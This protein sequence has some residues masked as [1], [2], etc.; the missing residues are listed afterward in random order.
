M[1]AKR[2]TVCIS[3]A[4]GERLKRQARMNDCSRSAVV[5]CALENYLDSIS[6]CRS[7]YDLAVDA[8]LISHLHGTPT[9]LSV[10]RRY[11]NGFGKGR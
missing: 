7:A 4:I 10:N 2:I 1:S 8:G 11:L 6:T 3:P 5:R 9:D